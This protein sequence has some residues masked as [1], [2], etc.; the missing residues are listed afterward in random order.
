[1]A[2]VE[3]VSVY[4]VAMQRLDDLM[5]AEAHTLEGEELALL[6]SLVEFYE[7]NYSARVI[8]L[9]MENIK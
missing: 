4:D 1:M 9:A 6:A 7:V 5:D 8:R 2:K 3:V